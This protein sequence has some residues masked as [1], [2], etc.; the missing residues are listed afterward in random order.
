MANSKVTFDTTAFIKSNSDLGDIQKQGNSVL[1]IKTQNWGKI[2]FNYKSGR[3][4]V[5]SGASAKMHEAIVSAIF[6]KLSLQLAKRNKSYTVFEASPADFRRVFGAVT[7][8]A[9]MAKAKADK[10]AKPK[11]ERKVQASADVKAAAARI[12]AIKAKNLEV[13]KSV[14][15][16]RA[17]NLVG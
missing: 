1:F 11:A 13:I 4:I 2:E 14:A 10:V 16:K 12:Q 17:A 3:V 15:A 6:D 5:G 8:V 7:S 9:P